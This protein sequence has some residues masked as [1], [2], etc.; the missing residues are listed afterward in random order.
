MISAIELIWYVTGADIYDIVV[1]KFCH[2]KKPCQ[3]I[4]LEVDKSSE[5]NFYRTILSLS[6]AVRLREEGDEESPH[7]VKEIA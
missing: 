6:L 2:E 4:L 5:V 7:D 3:I 1:S